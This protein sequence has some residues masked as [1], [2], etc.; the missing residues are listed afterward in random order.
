MIDWFEPVRGQCTLVTDEELRGLVKYLRAMG[1]PEYHQELMEIK[2]IADAEGTEDDEQFDEAVR[3]VLSEGRGSTSLL[4]RALK[5][6]YGRAARLIESMAKMG[7][8][9]GHNGSNARQ[10]LITLEEWDARKGQPAAR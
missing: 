2:T 8:V 10:I 9:G 6:G 3:V 7:L 1:K 5:V 4:Q